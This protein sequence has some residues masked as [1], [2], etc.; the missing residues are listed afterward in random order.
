MAARGRH[1]RAAA[2]FGTGVTTWP[3][4]VRVLLLLPLLYGVLFLLVNVVGLLDLWSSG[5]PG[6]MCLALWCIPVAY[7]VVYGPMW[8]RE[9]WR[10]S[11]EWKQ[12]QAEAVRLRARLRR[13][14]DA[15]RPPDPR[16]T[17]PRR[18]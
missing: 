3:L 18:W 17:P 12:D 16:P 8:W 6:G 9:V 4:W 5:E 15:D 2:R 14:L 1:D 13:Q 10:S 11:E 7:A